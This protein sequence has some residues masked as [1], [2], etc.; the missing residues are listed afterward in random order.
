MGVHLILLATVLTVSPQGA[1]LRTGCGA[2]DRSLASLDPGVSLEVRFALGSCYAVTVQSDGKALYGFVVAADVEGVEEWDAQRRSARAVSSLRDTRGPA[3]PLSSAAAAAA[4][5]MSR[6]AQL[7][8]DNRPGEALA[9]AE[10][11]LVAAPRDP[12]LLA[13]AGVAAL[14][15]D[16][17]IRGIGFL[18]DSL[19]LRED[20]ALRRI[21][22]QAVAEHA[23]DN[24]SSKLHSARFVFRWDPQILSDEDAR[25][26]LGALEQEYS[27]ISLDLGCRSPERV[28]VVAQSRED[29]L[30]TTGAAEWSGGQY[31]G[32]IRVAILN[33]GAAGA[34]TRRALAHEAVHACLAATGN[35]PAWFHE[36]LAMWHS[37]ERLPES[38]KVKIR[39]AAKA[40]AIPLLTNLR[41]SWSRMS[42]AHAAM[43]YSAALFAVELFY[44]HHREFGIRTLI[45]NHDH[46]ERIAASL[47]RLMRE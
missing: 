16:M 33:G 45:Q 12:Q 43:A 38:A 36:G 27:R 40:N 46:L 26:L 4:N 42:A 17:V 1:Q 18:K 20:P 34:E 29:Y 8:L 14:R 32:R 30:R 25:T 41:Q 11:A 15:N 19:A 31:D 22:D 9:V 13:L 35:W 5:P 24:S 2:A 23:A 6:G 10:Q 3:P 7:L 47:D 44:Q 28:A 39:A 21:L 37:G